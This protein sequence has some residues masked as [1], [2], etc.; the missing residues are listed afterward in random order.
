[1]VTVR[2]VRLSWCAQISL[3]GIIQSLVATPWISSD[4]VRTFIQT[5]MGERGMLPQAFLQTSNRNV[6]TSA[7]SLVQEFL[8]SKNVVVL[9]EVY[10]LLCMRMEQAIMSLTNSKQFLPNNNW[11]GVR[12]GEEL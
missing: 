3:F 9:Q 6:Q 12:L 1:M 2:G 5:T 8:Q 7:V 11:A 10:S 4:H